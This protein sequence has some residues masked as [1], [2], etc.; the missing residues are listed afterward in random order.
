M[1][2][3]AKRTF[4][5][6]SLRALFYGAL[7]LVVVVVHVG[8][9]TALRALGWNGGASLFASGAVVLML[10]LALTNFGDWIRERRA[11]GREMQRIRQGLP[12]GP[13]CV[14]WK[15]ADSHDSAAE[16]MPW[17]VVGHLRAR[18]PKLAQR[19]GIEGVAV[20]DF[21]INAQGEAKNIHCVYAWPSDVFF[22][23]ARE[24]LAHARFSP[25]PDT[26]PRFG[27]SFRMP[28]VFR[29]SGAAQVKERGR[30]ARVL[31]P[32]LHAARLVVE[33]LRSSA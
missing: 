10:V 3:W 13:C 30:R 8:L 18:Y 27:S 15:S 7:F 23:A 1:L 22:E 12:I 9:T 16:A 33:K 5:T 24:A 28:F 29:I 11:A 4:S 6:L 2:I 25:K 31:R 32:T 20:A 17:D 19:L 26:H 14:V 21:E